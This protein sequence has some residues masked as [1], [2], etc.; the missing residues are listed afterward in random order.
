ML[1]WTE[2]KCDQFPI[3]H[4]RWTSM[5]CVVTQFPAHV[6]RWG[7][8]ILL[9]Q[10]GW[11]INSTQ[12][13]CRGALDHPCCTGASNVSLVAYAGGGR[14]FLNSTGVVASL[15]TE[16]FP[17]NQGV[18]HTIDDV[19]CIPAVA[20][21][22]LLGL[23]QLPLCGVCTARFPWSRCALGMTACLGSIECKWNTS[24]DIRVFF[25]NRKL[26]DG[27]SNLAWVH[28]IQTNTMC[29]LTTKSDERGR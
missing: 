2:K 6:R 13:K 25:T 18:V 23:A 28:D 21:A 16:A 7:V 14:F 5:S 15:C 26:D 24:C 4:F 17:S 12:T 9:S 3:L 22:R 11:T 10:L 29:F 19:G 8:P 27:N 1:S 20:F